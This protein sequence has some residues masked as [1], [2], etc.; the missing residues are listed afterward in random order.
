M[1]TNSPAGTDL[2]ASRR[3]VDNLLSQQKITLKDIETLSKAERAYMGKKATRKLE[4]L[5]GIERDSYLE[6]I[7]L[8]LTPDTNSDIWEHNHDNVSNAIAKYMHRYGIMP[9]KSELAHATGLS[10]QTIAKHMQE[11]KSHPEFAAAKE[12]FKLM[13]HNVLA[14]VFTFASNGDM[15]AARLYFEMVGAINKQPIDTVVTEQ[16]NYIQINNTILSQENL[17]QLSAEQLTQIEN[18]VTNKEC[19]LL[20]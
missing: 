4:Q 8:I 6:K 5:K 14:K 16:N 9:T 1:K 19:K 3:K 11:Y 7:A 13:T 20:G 17:K 2:A 18:I 10:R 12:Q 15:K